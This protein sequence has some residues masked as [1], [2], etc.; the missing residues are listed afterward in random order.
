MNLRR[1]RRRSN[2]FKPHNLLT[3]TVKHN[4]TMTKLD[5]Q[6]VTNSFRAS[7]PDL[8][9]EH[10][11]T[12]S[13][14]TTKTSKETASTTSPPFRFVPL[15]MGGRGRTHVVSQAS[16]SLID[17]VTLDDLKKMTEGFYQKAFQ[18]VTLDKFIRSHG[19]DHGGRFAKWIHQKLSGS[20]VWDQDR[21]DRDKTPVEVAD[22]YRHVVH[23]R[24][25]AH[26]AA[27]YSPKR[28]SSEVGQHF[29]L[30]ECRVWM[31]LHFWAMRESGIMEKSPSFADYYVRFIG[32]FVRVYESSAPMFARES[33]RWSANPSN[34]EEYIANGRVM[35]DVLGVSLEDAAKELPEAEANDYVWPYN[36]TVQ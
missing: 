33:L 17:E 23:D 24:S 5:L 6:E 25:S 4:N 28:P 2:L 21:R 18:D 11:A 12:K 34:T 7:D 31:R 15:T 13:L 29:K 35:K 9:E 32:H 22:G 19:D 1:L 8:T 26:V 36:Q 10:E 20:K 27:W 30:D 14:S 16:A 3:I